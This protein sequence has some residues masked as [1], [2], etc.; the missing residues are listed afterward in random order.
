MAQE[1]TVLV[2]KA[3]VTMRIATLG[4]RENGVVTPMNVWNSTHAMIAI[5]GQTGWEE[6]GTVLLVMLAQGLSVI[7]FPQITVVLMERAG[8]MVLL[9]TQVKGWLTS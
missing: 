3:I 5:L 9:R 8:Y 2:E 1:T 7:Q 6:V 4:E